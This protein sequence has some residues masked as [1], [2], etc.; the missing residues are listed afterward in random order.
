MNALDRNAAGVFAFKTELSLSVCSSSSVGPWEKGRA[1]REGRGREGSGD[2]GWGVYPEKK[3]CD[4]V[5]PTAA[6]KQPNNR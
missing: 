3:P 1:G 2:G 6:T 4:C 5:L